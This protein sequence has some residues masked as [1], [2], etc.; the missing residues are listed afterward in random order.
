MAN[1]TLT[2]DIVAKTAVKILENELGM[3][4][5]VFRGYEEEFSTNVNGYKVGDTVRI[6]KPTAFTVRSGNVATAQDVIEGSTTIVVNRQRGVDFKF[7]SSDLTLKIDQLAE[8]V[9]KPAMVEL[10]QEMDTA[11][12][13]LYTDIPG[14]VGTLGST[15]NGYASFARARQYMNE[16]AV[17]TGERSMAI[18]PADETDATANLTGLYISR[19]AERAYR[20]GE[21]GNV[22]GIDVFS[23]QNVQTFTAGTRT[24]GTVNGAG[25]NVTYSG[26]QA[27]SWTQ[28]L[29][30]AGMGANG[31]IAA[32]DVFTISN[33]FRINP[34]TRQRI[35]TQLQQFTV[36]SAIAA[37]GAGAVTVTIS[38]PII[39][40][41]AFQTVALNTGTSLPSGGTVTWAATASTGYSQNLAFHKNAF[42]LV[43]VPMVKPPGAVDVSRQT[44]KNGLSVRVIPVY[45]GITDESLW[46][47]DVLY[48]VK[49]IDPRLAVRVAR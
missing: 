14:Y 33:V 22:A 13:G 23:T 17:P 19:S 25:Q 40:S 36:T 8:R 47:L 12:L 16:W 4:S 32:G 7:T 39:T 1:T 29:I 46:R 48:G 18:S 41:G 28:S 35:G 9:I 21:L 49:T 5:R 20:D 27:N 15:L 3:A 26:A 44:T 10:A 30:L 2:T 45:D 34:R 37:D 31:T 24:N 11:L 43:T 42:S 6:R 38:P